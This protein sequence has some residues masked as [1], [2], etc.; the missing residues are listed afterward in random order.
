MMAVG[1]KKMSE[2]QATFYPPTL[3]PPF[4]DC[5][6]PTKLDLSLYDSGS[7]GYFHNYRN[8]TLSK[9]SVSSSIQL[10]KTYD[11]EKFFY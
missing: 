7:I 8:E 3:M 11:V 1:N 6:P 2:I 5:Y 4:M 9:F 10:I